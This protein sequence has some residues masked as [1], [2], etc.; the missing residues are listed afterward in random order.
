MS[1]CLIVDDSAVIR[2]VARHIVESFKFKTAEAENGSVALSKCREHMPDAVLLDWNMP[3]MD[4]LQFIRA[5]R[6]EQQGHKPK[7]IFCTTE[8]DA[9]HISTAMSAGADE[10]VMKPFDKS[11]LQSKFQQ[12]GLLTE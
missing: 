10:F 4:G 5:L 8:N 6:E 12:V 2:K 9:D 11:I 7:V 1:Y 3:M